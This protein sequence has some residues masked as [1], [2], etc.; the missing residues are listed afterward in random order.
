MRAVARGVRTSERKT[1]L[2]LLAGK[3]YADPKHQNR[4]IRERADFTGHS[5]L[6]LYVAEVKQM[7]VLGPEKMYKGK[8]VDSRE[9][10]KM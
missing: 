8:Y 5:P 6:R 4:L 2:R 7:W 10:V 1:A 3:I 9:E